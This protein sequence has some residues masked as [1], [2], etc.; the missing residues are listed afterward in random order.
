MCWVA[1]CCA[2]LF[3]F[4]CVAKLVGEAKSPLVVCTTY[5]GILHISGKVPSLP[6]VLKATGLVPASLGGGSSGCLTARGAEDFSIDRSISIGA[7]LLP[8]TTEERSLV[9][10]PR[11]NVRTATHQQSAPVHAPGVMVWCDGAGERRPGVKYVSPIHRPA[12]ARNRWTC[13]RIVSRLVSSRA[14]RPQQLLL[15]YS[16]VNVDLKIDS[17][18]VETRHE[19]DKTLDVTW[20][21]LS[22]FQTVCLYLNPAVFF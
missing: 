13:L 19:T 20:D 8:R 15:Q 1:W 18:V 21:T 6:R 11:T 12:T 3:F 10:V 5:V 4:S 14:S 2:L 16:N 9:S 7:S 17:R 22:S